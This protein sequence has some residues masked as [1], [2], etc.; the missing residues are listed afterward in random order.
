MTTMTQE[1]EIAE[2]TEILASLYAAIRSLRHEIEALSERVRGGEPIS[3][4][5][6]SKPMTDMRGLVAQCTKAELLLNEC[7]NKQAGIARGDY[8]LNLD[9]ARVEIGCKLDRL[10]RCSGPGPVS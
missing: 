4:T 3:E 7:R 9:R 5:S 1:Q 10:R 6:V 2:G 8:A